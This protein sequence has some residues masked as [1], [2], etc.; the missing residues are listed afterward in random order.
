MSAH[1]PLAF[2]VPVT[3]ARGIAAVLTAMTL[4]LVAGSAGAVEPRPA[5]VSPSGFDNPYAEPLDAL[6]GET[7]AQYLV[8]RHET[9]LALR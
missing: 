3:S 7:L 9:R 4:A 2:L 1:S 5:A 8:R 6:G